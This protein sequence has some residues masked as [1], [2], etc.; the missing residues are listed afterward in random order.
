MAGTFDPT[1]HRNRML[2]G[3][4]GRTGL[5]FDVRQVPLWGE[6]G[7]AVVAQPKLPLLLRLARALPRLAWRAASGPR[8]DVAL[9]LYPG[10]F[11][12]PVVKAL[13]MLRGV[14]VVYDAF[15]SLHDTV[16]ADR[17]LRPERSLLGRL[18][19]GVDFLATRSGDLVLADT[20][21]DAEFFARQGAVSMSRLR[22]LWVGAEE[23]LFHPREAARP[24]P[25]LVLFYGTFIPLHGVP[26]IVRA[27][28]LLR[29]SGVRFRLIGRG[30]E[31]E[32][33]RA[34]VSRLELPNVELAPPV[35]LSR[36]P[37]EIARAAVCLGIFGTSGKAL[38][39]VPSKVF[40][41][42]AMGR[43]VVT[44]DTPAIR[45][46][47]A[48]GEIVTTPPG[49]PEALAA[50]ILELVRDPA[51]AE[52]VA[53]AGRA[54]FARDYSEA[55]LADRLRSFLSEAASRGSAPNGVG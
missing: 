38:R 9:V 41:C 28:S 1:F 18:L 35:P 54:R 12:V 25:G 8:P 55:V 52:G 47:F 6:R 32:A 46:A 30:Q 13:S 2:L 27:A 48:S 33:V 16:V 44:G 20:P 39:V 34:L 11:D 10:H 21:A 29:S 43:P 51:R 23:S 7:D 37:E 24:E 3:L 5:H 50:A 17:R 36:L 31:L 40:Q 4:L 45:S 15:L 19:R 42:L 49:D 26:T 22:V 53:R 14:P